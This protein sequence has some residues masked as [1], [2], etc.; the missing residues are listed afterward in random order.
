MGQL[1]LIDRI[2]VNFSNFVQKNSVRILNFLEV[3]GLSFC[4]FFI[5]ALKFGFSWKV[6]LASIAIYFVYQ[7]IITDFKIIAKN[8]SR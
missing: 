6:L 7:E 8:F 2:K 5:L 3:L 1:S 4:M